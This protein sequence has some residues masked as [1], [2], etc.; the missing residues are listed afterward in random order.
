MASGEISET[1]ARSIAAQ[2]VAERPQDDEPM[3]TA[4]GKVILLGEHAAV[5]GKHALALPIPGAVTATVR[6]SANLTLHVPDWALSREIVPDA[7]G[8]DAVVRSQSPSSV[9]STA[10]SPCRSTTSA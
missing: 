2:L 3:G 4:A 10:C 5:Y 7:E 1:R 8:V 9:H 6:E